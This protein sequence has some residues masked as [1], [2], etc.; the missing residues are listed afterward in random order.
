MKEMIANLFESDVLLSDQYWEAHSR[1][2]N[3]PPEK[4]LMLAVL[5]DAISCFQ[6]YLLLRDP[7]FREAEEW[8]FDENNDGLFSFESVCETLK[9]YVLDGHQFQMRSEHGEGDS[10]VTFHVE[11]WETFVAM[12]EKSATEAD[13]ARRW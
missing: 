6:K 10:R 7:K 3:L 12:L 1:K 11:G 5:E 2:V 13:W 4:S 8:I 9:Q